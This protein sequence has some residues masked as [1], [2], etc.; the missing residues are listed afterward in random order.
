MKFIILFILAVHLNA[1]SLQILSVK[2]EEFL[3]VKVY[4][5][6]DIVC[7][8]CEVKI[9]TQNETLT[10][11]TDKKGKLKIPLHLN[12]IKIIATEKLGHKKILNLSKEKIAQNTQIKLPFWLKIFI[13]LFIILSFFL[14]LRWAK[15]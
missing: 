3:N 8:E 14:G 7:Q 9:I 5:T 15:K 4:F 6:Q 10:Y 11:K 2:D 12:P 13:G 1:H